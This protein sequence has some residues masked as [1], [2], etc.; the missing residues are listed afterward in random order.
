MKH[1]IEITGMHCIGCSNLIKLSL[2]D[3]GFDDVEIDLANGI[4]NFRSNKDTQET[5]Q[6]LQDVFVELQDYEFSNLQ[7]VD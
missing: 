1:Q 3:A 2:E 7:L 4:G 5:E 6:I